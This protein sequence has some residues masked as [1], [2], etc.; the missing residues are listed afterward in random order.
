M[1]LFLYLILLY[2][3]T[4][5]IGFVLSIIYSNCFVIDHIYIEIIYYTL[6]AIL[7]IMTINVLLSLVI[8]NHIIINGMTIIL[9][10][11]NIFVINSEFNKFFPWSYPVLMIINFSE[12]SALDFELF[13]LLKI[14]II[15]SIITL[16]NFIYFK[17]IK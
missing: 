15:F 6:I 4:L 14:I 11:S 5:F 13:F 17:K 12:N 10:I 2:S 8:R 16:F 9:S 7:P 1:V 3:F